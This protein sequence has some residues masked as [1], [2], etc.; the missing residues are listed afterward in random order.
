[1]HRQIIGWIIA[2]LFV[3]SI[4]HAARLGIPASHATHSGIGVISGWKCTAEGDLTIVFNDTGKHIPLL[5][6]S[7]RPDVRKNGQCLDNDHDNV[8]FVAIWNWGELGDGQHTAVVYDDGVE[9]DRAYFTVVT[10]GVAFLQD[11]FSD[12][13]TLTLSNGQTAQVEW[14]EPRQGF[15]ATEYSF[16]PGT[17]VGIGGTGVCAVKETTISSRHNNLRLV[18]RNPCEDGTTLYI[19][20]T[21]GP[22]G[23][24]IGDYFLD[25]VQAGHSYYGGHWVDG[26]PPGFYWIDL[27]DGNRMLYGADVD[28]GA[29]APTQLVVNQ[30]HP[31][32]LNFLEPY[33]IYWQDTLIFVFP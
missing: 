27:R 16:P 30:E 29:M 17:G 10:P 23:G 9:F 6:G 24:A 20:A 8:G 15:V 4:A 26:D 22:G 2:L 25:I 33:E 14:S 3:S 1:M 11:V 21:G 19:D 31:T 32:P 7:E 5:Y 18:V 13:C 28:A 12:S